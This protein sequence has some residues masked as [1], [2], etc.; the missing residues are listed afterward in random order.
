[1]DSREQHWLSGNSLGISKLDA[2]GQKDFKHT[3]IR[4]IRRVAITSLNPQHQWSAP[5]WSCNVLSWLFGDG[6]PRSQQSQGKWDIN[7]YH[8]MQ[9][10]FRNRNFNPSSHTFGDMGCSKCKVSGSETK[11]D[12]LFLL[13]FAQS[14]CF[15]QCKF[16][17]HCVKVP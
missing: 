13:G 10:Y 12:D 7:G 3:L 15:V 14:P 11:G 17:Q 16:L 2:S 5:I 6:H 8:V 4:Y 9:H 1:M